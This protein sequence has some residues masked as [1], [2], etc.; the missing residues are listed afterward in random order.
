MALRSPGAPQEARPRISL[1]RHRLSLDRGRVSTMRTRSPTCASF[2]SSCA[3]NR[4]VRFTTRWYRGWRN[5]R[6]TATTRVLGILS[7]TTTPTRVFVTPGLPGPSRPPEPE[8][9]LAE[10]RLHPGQLPPRLPDPR[11]VL[12]HRHRDLEP[13]VEDL[14]PELARLLRELAVAQVTQVRPPLHRPASLRRAAAPGLAVPAGRPA[15]PPGRRRLTPAPGARTSSGSAASG[16]RAGTPPGPRPRSS[17]PSRR[18]SGP[19]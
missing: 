18:G 2:R 10:E 11:R 1:I 16:W 7:L 19:A 4:L 6:S 9:P 12:G 17:P 14:L 5:A 3:L 8:R 15:A 13:E